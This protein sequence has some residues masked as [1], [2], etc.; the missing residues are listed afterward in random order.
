MSA[1]KKQAW[2]CYSCNADGYVTYNDADKPAHV[3]VR[4]SQAH[5]RQSPYCK[6]ED[7]RLIAHGKIAVA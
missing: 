1:V 7:V 2:F 3:H 6:A 5:T 4:V